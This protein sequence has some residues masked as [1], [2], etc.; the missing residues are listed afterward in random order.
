MRYDDVHF[1]GWPTLDCTA[2]LPVWSVFPEGL[3]E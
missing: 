1:V 2:A 3:P